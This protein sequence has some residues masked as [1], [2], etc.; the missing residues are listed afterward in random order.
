MTVQQPVSP[1]LA[2]KNIARLQARVR[3]L[4]ARI[5][6]AGGDASFLKSERRALKF[7][8]GVLEEMYPPSLSAPREEWRKKG[9]R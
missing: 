1:Y 8:L 7:A 3:W 5:E 6:E 4:D 2:R 9:N